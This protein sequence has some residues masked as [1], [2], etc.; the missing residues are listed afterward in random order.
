MKNVD[1]FSDSIFFS[2]LFFISH[3]LRRR[4]AEDEGL[5]RHRFNVQTPKDCTCNDTCRCSP[6]DGCMVDWCPVEGYGT[7]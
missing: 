5:S 3:T 4:N 6:D 7:F 1:F 2:V